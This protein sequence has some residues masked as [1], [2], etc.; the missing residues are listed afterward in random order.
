VP[1]SPW[2]SNRG[3]LIDNRSDEFDG[4]LE[5]QWRWV[6]EPNGTDGKYAPTFTADGLEWRHQNAD[7]F[8]DEN[9]AS[10]L[11]QPAPSATSSWRRASVWASG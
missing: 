3:A 1:V 10:V 11:V 7:L 5:D 4:G 6:R 8:V 9:N 2:R